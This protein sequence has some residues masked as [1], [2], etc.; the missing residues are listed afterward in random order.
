M[1]KLEKLKNLAVQAA[2]EF[3]APVIISIIWTFSS[4]SSED[5]FSTTD[6]I[7]NFASC[8][9]L[10]S[11]AIGQAFRIWKQNNNEKN[12]NLIQNKSDSIMNE[13]QNK[14]DSLFSKIEKDSTTL[15]GNMT[16]GD[17]FPF[18][19]CFI[20][21]QKIHLSAINKGSYPIYDINCSVANQEDIKNIPTIITGLDQI[22]NQHQF[23]YTAVLTPG[24]SQIT[25]IILDVNFLKE[26]VLLIN[27]SAR[28][29][30]FNQISRITY[31]GSKFIITSTVTKGDT[32]IFREET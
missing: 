21:G 1:T 30:T 14:F 26:T 10:T 24:T 20:I 4:K 17:S 2:K 7:K 12:I 16:G 8:F 19:L 27:T 9:F 25:N 23:F 28:N 13:I 22:F 5:T 29:G 11:W 15:M 3:A 31:N 6:I 18:Y 32:E